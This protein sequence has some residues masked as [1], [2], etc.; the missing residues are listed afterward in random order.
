[1][2]S[3]AVTMARALGVTE[4]VIGMSIVALGTSLPELAASLVSAWKGATEISIGNVI[5]SNI[6]NILFVL[7]LCPMIR[8]IQ[9][10]QGVL[11]FEFPI[12]FLFSLALFPL[13][14]PGFTINR[15]KGSLL[16]GAYLVFIGILFR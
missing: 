5:G 8:P 10:D 6:F 2:V 7:G 15:S 1:M 11:G 16:L 13:I 12:M 9:M 4:L 14:W 3:S